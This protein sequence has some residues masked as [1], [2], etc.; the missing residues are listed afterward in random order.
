MDAL[1]PGRNVA[2]RHMPAGEGL[3]APEVN[4]LLRVRG[5][6]IEIDLYD[7]F[8]IRGHVT[9]EEATAALLSY[10]YD[11]LDAEAEIERLFEHGYARIMPAQFHGLR[12]VYDYLVHHS[13]P[14][15]G[16]FPVT[17]VGERL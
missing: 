10:G 3:E 5:A 16:A 2:F 4:D 7:G 14:G 11:P 8:C 1:G 17:Y 6:V 12:D 13:E 9:P 15:K